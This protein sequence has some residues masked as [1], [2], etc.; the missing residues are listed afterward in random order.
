MTRSTIP[1]T[2]VRSCL[3][4]VTVCPTTVADNPTSTNTSEKPAT[5]NR[6]SRATFPRWPRVSVTV[7]MSVPVTTESTTGRIGNTQ[8]ETNDTRPP[9]KAA[10]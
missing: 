5:N 7:V 2:R 1:E 9:P 3:S 6:V 10:R 4:W 8:G